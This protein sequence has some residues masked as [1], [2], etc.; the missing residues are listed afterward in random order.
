MGEGQY[1]L[2]TKDPKSAD[3]GYLLGSDGRAFILD[4][5]AI[6]PTLRAP[7]P[8]AYRAN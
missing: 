7:V 1:L 2:A 4:Q 6:E 3:R 5:K 8:E